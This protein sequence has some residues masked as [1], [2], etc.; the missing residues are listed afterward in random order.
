MKTAILLLAI[1]LCNAQAFA[2]P[3]VE[4]TY[5]NAGNRIQRK[6]IVLGSNMP[7]NGNE[8]AHTSEQEQ[9][10]LTEEQLGGVSYSIYPNPTAD[11]LFIDVVYEGSA[12]SSPLTLNLYSI[13]GHLLQTVQLTGATHTLD[14][15]P[16]TRGNYLLD[17]SSASGASRQIKV[18]KQ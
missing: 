6:V 4:Y 13:S 9:E 5:D 17:I 2:Q 8:Q 15:T 16:Y 7:A 14:M 3:A 18:V 10:Q 11:K 12:A 1:L